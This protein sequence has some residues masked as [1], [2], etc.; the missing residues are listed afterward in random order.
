LDETADT[1]TA[2]PAYTVKAGLQIVYTKKRIMSNKKAQEN[3][4]P[5]DPSVIT[6][7]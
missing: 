6:I 4:H 3:T 2:R 1:R 5:L 7:V